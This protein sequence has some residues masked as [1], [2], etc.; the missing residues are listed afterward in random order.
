ME[1]IN[2]KR[3][4]QAPRRPRVVT[5]RLPEGTR[6]ITDPVDNEIDAHAHILE[7]LDPSHFI[8]K[9]LSIQPCDV[10][11]IGQIA[12]PHHVAHTETLK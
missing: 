4:Q 5:L 12:M 11:N 9:T 7:T 2:S 8:S 6:F 10:A 3:T 1:T